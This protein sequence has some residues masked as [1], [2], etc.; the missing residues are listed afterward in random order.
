M[1]QLGLHQLAAPENAKFDIVFVH[2]LF[3]NRINTWTADKGPLWPQKL[4]SQDVTDARIFT[5]GYDADV[6]KL[7]LDEELTEGTME[8]H[9]ADL[10]ERLSSFRAMTESSDRPLIF[11]A[12]SLGGL[13]CAQLVV[14]GALGA[15]TDN[16]AIVSNNTRGMIFLGTP[17]HGSPIAPLAKVFSRMVSVLRNTHTQKVKDLEQKSEKLR[18]LAESFA[19]ALHQRIRDNKE[20]RVA[21]FHETKTLNGVLVVPELNARI[22]GFGDH[23]SIE[24][25]HEKMCKFADPEEPGYQ[26]V[27]AAIRKMA[28]DADNR[29]DATTHGIQYAN[30]YNGNIKNQVNGN[31]TIH[32]GMHFA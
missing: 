18:I 6:I 32:G 10:C 21:F 23:A 7:N 1:S 4:L 13:I 16:V 11:V 17:F 30:T 2:G 9:A 5:F 25:N 15:E 26:S 24:A 14:K 8:T 19:S 22:P 3:G 20:I 28:A 27:V 31:Q 29:P 12:H